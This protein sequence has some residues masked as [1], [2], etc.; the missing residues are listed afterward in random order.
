MG[1]ED[2]VINKLTSNNINSSVNLTISEWFTLNSIFYQL[3][4]FIKE[5]AD[6]IYQ[7]VLQGV[8]SMTQKENDELLKP[9]EK[10]LSEKVA[11]S[12]TVFK[13]RD[14]YFITVSINPIDWM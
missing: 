4:N 6:L 8:E 12:V 1:G 7:S 2:V 14:H 11:V 13:P 9:Y 5:R 3:N 10:K